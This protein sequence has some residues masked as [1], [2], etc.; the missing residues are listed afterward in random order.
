MK[1]IRTRAVGIAAGLAVG[2]ASISVLPNDA[3]AG[4]FAIREQSAYSQGA[5]FAG[6]ATCGESVQGMYWNSAIVT[7]HAGKTVEG[8]LSFII[9]DTDIT[10][11]P[12]ST[13]AP[14]GNPG[15]Y[16]KFGA[17]PSNSASW[18]LSDQWYIGMTVNGPYGQSTQPN[19]PS[20]AVGYARNAKIFSTNFNP[21][22]GYKV[23][24]SLSLAVG[25]QAQWF[26]VI[27]FSRRSAPGVAL[28]LETELEGEDWG[29]G[30]TFGALWRPMEG[31]EIGVGYR[32]AVKHE[33]EGTLNAPIIGAFNT[34][35]TAEVDLPDLA[36]VSLR[37]RLNERWTLLGTFEWSNWSLLTQSV[38]NA[39]VPL[40]TVP[41][42]I[43]E[44]DDGFYYSLGAEYEYSDQL[45]LRAGVAWEESPI[46]DRVRSPV[47]PDDDR[48][49][50]SF[51]GTYDYNE[52]LS[53]NFGYSFITTFDTQISVAPGNP[54]FSA[55][56][57]TFFG[58]VSNTAHILAFGAKYKLGDNGLGLFQ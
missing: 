56:G 45:T 39:T 51:G 33:L 55:A 25:L 26:D 27:D 48:L 22:I 50:L 34:P 12:G 30:F 49:W 41:R 47:L 10:T 44:Y 36:T 37:Q 57:G 40:A 16:A 24:E 58:D 9:P 5:S 21:V 52:K 43:F 54:H 28:G 35:V 53:F 11:L 14:L 38:V 29:F 4:A 42:V 7:C 6:N 13:F 1:R 8:S 46:S 17:V 2:A 23:N 18:Q 3:E 20:A 32:S 15:S 31:T 19:D